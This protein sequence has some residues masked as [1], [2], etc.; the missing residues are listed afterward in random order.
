MLP[1]GT[2]E[3]PVDFSS[4]VLNAPLNRDWITHCD[5]VIPGGFSYYGS[6]YICADQNGSTLEVAVSIWVNFKSLGVQ[7]GQNI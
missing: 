2:K 7:K 1:G 3:L 5:L 6:Q 4:N